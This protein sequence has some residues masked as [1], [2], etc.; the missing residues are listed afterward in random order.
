MQNAEMNETLRRLELSRGGFARLL[1][2][3]GDPSEPS[4]IRRRVER[5]GVGHVKIP[6]EVIALLNVLDA[7]PAAMTPYWSRV[8]G[9]ASGARNTSERGT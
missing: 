3:L 4:A 1:K 5:W 6:G 9:S 8:M 7:N 2:L